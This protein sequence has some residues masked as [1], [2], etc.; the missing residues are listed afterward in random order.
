MAPDRSILFLWTR[1]EGRGTWKKEPFQGFILPRETG[2]ME[3]VRRNLEAAGFQVTF[4]PF[5]ETPG[6]SPSVC[7][8]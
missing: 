3:D 4:L 2:R 6:S 8:S 5:D 7:L 1:W